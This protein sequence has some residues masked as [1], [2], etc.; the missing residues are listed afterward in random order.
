ML[1]TIETTTAYPKRTRP[2]PQP[3]TRI[4]FMHDVPL[5]HAGVVVRCRLRAEL[6]GPD[7]APVVLVMGGISANAHATSHAENDQPGWWEAQVG[8]GRA[9][10][11]SLVRVLSFDWLGSDGSLNVPI[12]TADQA[13]ALVA[14]LDHLSIDRVHLVVGASYGAMVALQLAARHEL[15]IGEVV[16]ISGAHRPNPYASAWRSVQRRIL[17][18]AGDAEAEGVALARQLAMLSYRSP[19]EF[20]V[21]FA[22]KPT[23]V[24]NHARVAAE[25]YLESRGEDFA[26]RFSRTAFLRLSESIDLHSIEPE[27]IRV[28]LHLVAVDGDRLAPPEDIAALAEHCAGPCDVRVLSSIYGHDAFLREVDAIGAILSDALRTTQLNPGGRS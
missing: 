20:A 7:C 15:R 12:D 18:L 11:T 4:E 26:R 25:D 23:L 1:Q 22:A 3:G 5:R 14:I 16:A 24:A 21:R 17:A 27:E 2:A 13:A 10:D 6:T 8:R 19:E 9:L 28:P